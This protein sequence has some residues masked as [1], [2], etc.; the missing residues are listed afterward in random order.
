MSE[1]ERLTAADQD[2]FEAACHLAFH[3][4]AHPDTIE[5]DQRVTDPERSS[6]L[7]QLSNGVF[8]E[9]REFAVC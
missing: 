5:M 4:I 9:C 1:P 2:A 7:F 8:D 6:G 3:E